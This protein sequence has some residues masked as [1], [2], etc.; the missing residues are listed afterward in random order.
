M[1]I[2]IAIGLLFL[3]SGRASLSQ[4]KRATAALLIAFFPRFPR[5][6]GDNQYHLQPLRHLWVL[7]TDW[8]GL[9]TVDVD[10]CADVP[11]PLQVQLNDGIDFVGKDAADSLATCQ[12]L[13]VVAPCLLPPFRSITSVRVV[14]E[15]LYPAALDITQHGLSASRYLV[16]VKRRIGYLNVVRNVVSSYTTDQVLFAFA[17]AFCDYTG[18]GKLLRGVMVSKLEG[19]CTRILHNGVVRNE[20]ATLPLYLQLL[21]AALITSQDM[22]TVDSSVVSGSI[23]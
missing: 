17:R 8:R 6:A 5:Y 1:A 7:A 14:S 9:A 22:S 21:H 10:T 20:P 13:H 2:H 19:W 18:R 3:G 15:C 16:H 12:S 23:S 4:S 11:V